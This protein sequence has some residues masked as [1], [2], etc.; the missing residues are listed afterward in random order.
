M[1]RKNQSSVVSLLFNVQIY[2]DIDVEKL[3]DDRDLFKRMSGEFDVSSRLPDT[4]FFED[5]F[6][7]YIVESPRAE[8]YLLDAL[9]KGLFIGHVRIPQTPE[10]REDLEPLPLT[11]RQKM[12]LFYRLGATDWPVTGSVCEESL[13]EAYRQGYQDCMLDKWR[14]ETEEEQFSNPTLNRKKRFFNKGENR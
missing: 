3:F 13:A 12:D 9:R 10:L 2:A 4:L 5:G 11:D 8:E 7:R 6:R 1:R 14:K